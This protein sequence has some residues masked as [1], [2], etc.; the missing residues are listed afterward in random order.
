MLKTVLGFVIILS[1]TVLGGYCSFRLTRRV[2]ILQSFVLLLQSAGVKITYSAENLY[3]VFDR[4]FAHFEF[5]RN[6]P[7]AV[8][9]HRFIDQFRDVLKAEDME[10][11]DHIADELG[12]SDTHSQQEYIQCCVQQVTQRLAEA[13]KAENSAGRLYRIL[14]PAIGTVIAIMMI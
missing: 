14:P 7:F 13:R 12:K 3:D 9:W 8:E 10:V 6:V 4:N 2:S 11:L 1:S 5:R